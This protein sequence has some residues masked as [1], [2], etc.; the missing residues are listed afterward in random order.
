MCGPIDNSTTGSVPCWPGVVSVTAFNPPPVSPGF[1]A[2]DVVVIRFSSP[3]NTSVVVTFSPPIGTTSRSWRAGNRE[4]WFTVIGV[5]GVNVSAVDVATGSLSVSVSGVFSADGASPSSVAVTLS[6]GGTW[7]MPSPP[8]I[9]DATAFDSGRNAGL[10]TNDTLVVTFD[11]AVRLVP[12]VQTPAVLGSLLTFQPPFPSS[13][14]AKGAWTSPQ[15]LTVSLTVGGDVL[16]DWALWN[17]GSLS[18]TVRPAS[19]LTSASGE[20]GASN[21]SAVMRG[22]SWGDAVGVAV[23]TKNSTAVAVTITMPLT[24]VGYAASTFVVQWSTSEAF[25]GV[26]PV[27][28]TVAGVQA[29]VQLGSSPSLVVDSIGRRVGSLLLLASSGSGF[30]PDAAVVTLASSTSVLSSPLQFDI[31]GLTTSTTYFIRGACNG[32]AGVMGPVVLSDPRSV[33]PQPPR[34]LFVGAPSAGLPTAGGAVL[35]ALGERLGAVESVVFMVLSSVDFEPVTTPSCVIVVPT[36]RIRCTSP[37]GVGTGL[38]VTVSVDGVVSPPYTNGTLSYMSPAITGLRVFAGGG[39]GEGGGVPTI[40]GGVVVLEGV[41]FGPAALGGRS[42]GAVSYSS[43][44]LTLLL[45]ASASFPALDCAITRSHTEVSCTMGPGVGGGLQWS[46]TI[47]GQTASTA[48]IS[49]RPPVIAAVGVVLP[50][51][52]VSFD[53]ASRHALATSGGQQLV[54]V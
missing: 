34:I 32:P 4:L 25:S 24:A 28:S 48:T 14:I 10:G 2:G 44:A 45:G 42:L 16:P 15:S 1:S 30:G 5:S 12:G 35:E 8:I 20:S 37:A 31:P 3:T 43:P 26:E 11:Q 21:S 27:P 46:I 7:G 50:N 9:V 49:Y 54:S 47:G 29:W 19:N 18:V 17:V 33:T 41:N 13:V 36:S 39:M 38:T 51:G 40:G 53:S 6:V 52:D 22:G 23:S